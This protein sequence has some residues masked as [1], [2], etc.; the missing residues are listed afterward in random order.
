[1]HG[2]ALQRVT[3]SKN[4][5]GMV[6]I[7]FGHGEGGNKSPDMPPVTREE[8]IALPRLVRDFE[9]LVEG[10]HRVWRIP[11]EDGNV[12]RIVTRHGEDR[13]GER[14]VSM[15]VGPLKEGEGVSRKKPPAASSVPGSSRNE[16]TG[17]GIT[18]SHPAGKQGA[19]HMTASSMPEGRPVVNYAVEQPDAYA[20]APPL[21]EGMSADGPEGLS[22]LPEEMR[23]MELEQAQALTERDQLELAQA[24]EAELQAARLDELG[25]SI[26]ECVWRAE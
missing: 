2:R 15:Y 25:Q 17:R 7:I 23:V 6:K 20:P 16:D 18:I 5:F 4:G 10:G 24:R 3:G 13:P 21:R 14:L 19:S 12:L 26:V 22:P 11:R 8:V 1:M 9:G